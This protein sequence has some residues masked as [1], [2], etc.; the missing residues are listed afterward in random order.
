[1][2]LQ[3]LRTMDGNHYGKQSHIDIRVI[4]VI[5]GERGQQYCRSMT[6]SDFDYEM[7][8]ILSHEIHVGHEYVFTESTVINFAFCQITHFALHHLGHADLL[9]STRPL[10]S[11]TYH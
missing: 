4:L 5:L 6:Y 8:H 11:N 9:P 1:M 7:L 3:A 2:H 10:H